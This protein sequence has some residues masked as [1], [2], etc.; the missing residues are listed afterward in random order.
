[1]IEV[2]PVLYLTTDLSF[3]DLLVSFAFFSVREVIS[4]ERFPISCSRAIFIAR[5]VVCTL[6]ACSSSILRRALAK[7]VSA[8]ILSP[9]S[10]SSSAF[11]RRCF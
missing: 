10:T 3:S 1:M 7:G 9:C 5:L 8:S 2:L 6:I 11:L 4:F